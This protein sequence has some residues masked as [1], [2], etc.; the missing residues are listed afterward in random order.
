MPL[1][2]S[3]R[4]SSLTSLE[5]PA[6]RLEEGFDRQ[7]MALVIVF[8]L[9]ERRGRSKP[10]VA[11]RRSHQVHAKTVRMRKGIDECV[12]ERSLRR[13]ELDVFATARVNR[14]RLS[15]EKA[16]DVV[17]VQARG[18]DDGAGAD[19]FTLRAQLHAI[20]MPVGADQP[21]ARQKDSAR[22]GAGRQQRLDERLGFDHARLGRPQSGD[23]RHRWLAR[24]DERAIDQFQP[25]HA[26]ARRRAP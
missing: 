17:G 15:S 11:V 24:D 26:I 13:R 8:P 10:D 25:V 4:S 5:Q 3:R 14:K 16:R 18:V 12:D 7:T 1:P 22:V 21:R 2:P 6:R 23:A 19:R 9:L 20:G